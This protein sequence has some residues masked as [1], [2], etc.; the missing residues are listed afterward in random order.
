MDRLKSSCA[1]SKFW[2]RFRVRMINHSDSELV[3]VLQMYIRCFEKVPYIPNLAEI[4]YKSERLRVKVRVYASL[5]ARSHPI[6][7]RQVGFRLKRP[8]LFIHGS[9]CHHVCTDCFS[10]RE[11]SPIGT[12]ADRNK[13]IER[14]HVLDGVLY[15]ILHSSSTKTKFECHLVTKSVTISRRANLRT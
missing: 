1:V 13:I 12:F 14:E 2:T 3:E 9:I 5:S 4:D 6:I 15:T 10:P 7:C 8:H 11:S